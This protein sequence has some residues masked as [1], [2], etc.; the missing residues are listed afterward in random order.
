ME[1]TDMKIGGDPMGNDGKRCRGAEKYFK[2]G[3]TNS[4]VGLDSGHRL[5]KW[6]SD[7]TPELYI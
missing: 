7:L 2:P 4:F 6:S 5:V 1:Y 3:K